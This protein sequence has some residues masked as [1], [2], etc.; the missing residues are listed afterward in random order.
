MSTHSKTDKGS[1]AP[2]PWGQ[3]PNCDSGK[4]CCAVTIIVVVVTRRPVNNAIT[5]RATTPSQR[6]QSPLRHRNHWSTTARCL[7]IGNV[8]NAIAIRA[9]TPCQWQQW[10]LRIDGNDTITTRATMPAQQRQGACASMT[11]T[12]LTNF[13]SRVRARQIRDRELALA[14]HLVWLLVTP[15]HPKSTTYSIF[16]G[17]KSCKIEYGLWLALQLVWLLVS[18]HLYIWFYMVKIIK[19]RI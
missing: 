3:Q 2:S 9:K 8:N 1:T 15:S 13:C 18:R 14:L 5:T 7:L 6:R 12:N 4:V 19:N 10:H 11:L 17:P 16:H